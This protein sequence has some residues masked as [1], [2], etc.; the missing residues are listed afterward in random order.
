MNKQSEIVNDIVGNM[1]IEY[2]HI[3]KV[4]RWEEECHGYHQFEDVT[5]IR[6]T[7]RKVVLRYNDLEIDITNRLKKDE[8][9]DLECELMP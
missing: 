8:I 1:E 5:T 9:K 3:F 4:D 2:E 7:I 6:V